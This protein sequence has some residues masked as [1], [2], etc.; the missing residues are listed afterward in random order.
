[1]IE[2]CIS[3]RNNRRAQRNLGVLAPMKN[4]YSYLLA[5]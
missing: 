3:Y 4:H 1:M 2:D 5:A